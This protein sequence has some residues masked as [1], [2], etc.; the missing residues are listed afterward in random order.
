M[1]KLLALFETREE[2]ETVRDEILRTGIEA[3]AIR[4]AT[5]DDLSSSESMAAGVPRNA[6]ILS[7]VSA[8]PITL[9]LALCTLIIPGAGYLL[10]AIAIVTLFITRPG[11]IITEHRESLLAGH[12][13][14]VVSSPRAST[15]HVREILRRYEIF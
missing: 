12:A 11:D 8:V 14:L 5:K 2:A 7:L 6:L 1:T 13:L 15:R 4:L 10:T 9:I 3:N